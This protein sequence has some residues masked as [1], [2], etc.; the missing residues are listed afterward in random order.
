MQPVPLPPKMPT[1]MEF[2][3]AVGRYEQNISTERTSNDLAA[4]LS[5]AEMGRVDC[6]FAALGAQA[7]GKLHSENGYT[8]P[9][10]HETEQPDDDDLL[11]RAVTQTICHGGTAYVV[12]RREVPGNAVAAALFRW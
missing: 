5:A 1:S 8:K 11:D 2:R 6:L 9:E 4:I 3:K 7:W 10:F 12:D